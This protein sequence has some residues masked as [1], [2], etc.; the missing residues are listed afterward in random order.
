MYCNTL[1]DHVKHVRVVLEAL[2]GAGLTAHSKKCRWG[3]QS[4]EFLGHQVGDG[5]M[6]MPAYRAQALGNYNLPSTKKGLRAFLGSIGF[7]RRYA[8]QLAS[9]AAVLTPLMAKQ[10]PHRVEW[11]EDSKCAFHK[12]CATISTACSLC[13]TLPSDCFSSVT[14]VSGLGIGGVLQVKRGDQ[15]EAAAFFSRQ[16]RGTEQRYSATELEALAFT[17]AD[18]LSREERRDRDASSRAGR[19]SSRGGC[20]GTASTDR[21]RRVA[22]TTG[23]T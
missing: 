13:I 1:D 20:G 7:Y 10:V 22:K 12:I 5:R 18:A 9:Q 2:R 15:W 17:M 23:S 6:S 11:T 3:G 8:E 4:M 19:L 16:L 14:D 21:E